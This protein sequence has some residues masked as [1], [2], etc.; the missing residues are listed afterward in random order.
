LRWARS[1]RSNTTACAPKRNSSPFRPL[2]ERGQR[3]RWQRCSRTRRN[4]A[5]WRSARTFALYHRIHGARRRD[6]L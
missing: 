3:P 2:R 4:S 6:A 1:I 5:S